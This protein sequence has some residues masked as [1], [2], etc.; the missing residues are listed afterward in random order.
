MSLIDTDA[1]V[2]KRIELPGVPFGLTP[3]RD[4]RLLAVLKNEEMVAVVDPEAGGVVATLPVGFGSMPMSCAVYG[5]RC[6]LTLGGSSEII[7]FPLELPAIG[8]P[9]PMDGPAPISA[10]PPP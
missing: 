8:G 4:G 9:H 10:L 3:L 6:F 2:L 1:N 7:E 5:D